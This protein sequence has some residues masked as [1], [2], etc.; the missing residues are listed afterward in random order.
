MHKSCK[1]SLQDAYYEASLFLPSA[2]Q[3]FCGPER[4]EKGRPGIVGFREHIFS[5][6]GLL[7][8]LA[9]DSE[10][11]F[12]TMIQRTLDWPLNSR[13]H[14]GHPDL[15]D[16]LQVVQQGGVSKGT[17]GL[18]LSEDIFAGLDLSLRGGWTT[19]REYFHVGKARSSDQERRDF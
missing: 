11:T 7:G 14:Y 16:K 13:F 3:E 18:N 17:R 4:T 1:L 5:A 6:V 8:R 9:A 19:Y 15:I 10:F 2:L 12:G